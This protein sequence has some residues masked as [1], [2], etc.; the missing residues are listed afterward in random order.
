MTHV[1]LFRYSHVAN[2]KLRDLCFMGPGL[3]S[4]VH[5]STVYVINIIIYIILRTHGLI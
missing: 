4:L 5:G 3:M 1:L 2:K